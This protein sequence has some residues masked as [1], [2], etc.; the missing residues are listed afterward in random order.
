MVGLSAGFIIPVKLNDLSYGHLG[1]LV[2]GI[3]GVV[4]GSIYFVFGST[5]DAS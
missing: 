2:E 5:K 3:G 4:R 1:P